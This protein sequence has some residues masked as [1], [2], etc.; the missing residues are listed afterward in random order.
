M[1]HC[2]EDKETA[3]SSSLSGLPALPLNTV[4]CWQPSHHWQHCVCVD[5]SVLHLWT[6]PPP[7][8]LL[9]FLRVQQHNH[10]KENKTGDPRPL[11]CISCFTREK[12]QEDVWR[13]LYC[14]FLVWWVVLY[15]ILRSAVVMTQWLLFSDVFCINSLSS[16]VCRRTTRYAAFPNLLLL[17]DDAVCF[18]FCVTNSSV[19]HRVWFLLC[20]KYGHCNR[21]YC[22]RYH[23]DHLYH[24]YCVLLRN[25]QESSRMG[26]SWWWAL[27]Y[28][29]CLYCCY[30]VRMFGG[31]TVD[32]HE[33]FWIFEQVK[34][35]FSHQHQRKCQQRS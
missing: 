2:R 35:I 6:L 25:P 14:G 7:D 27:T 31:N 4:T 29:N 1:W 8:I 10:S 3:A 13:S 9:L 24:H 18:G 5:T 15:V 19:F 11:L 20:P 26:L 28:C 22:L 32:W 12:H 33:H 34:E 23:L 16:R 21:H 30:Y 17:W